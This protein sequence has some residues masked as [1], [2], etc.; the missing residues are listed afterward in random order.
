M[1]VEEFEARFKRQMDKIR[2]YAR[3]KAPEA[4]GVE[5]VN[6]FKEAFDKEAFDGKKWE[7]VERRNS[8]SLWYGH[9]GQTGRFSEAR[10]T[11]RILTGETGDLRNAIRPAIRPGGVTIKNEKVYAAVHNFGGPANVYGKKPFTMKKRQFMGVTPELEK[12]IKEK[13]ERDIRNILNS[14]T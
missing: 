1:T 4:I 13:L 8:D 7:D 2:T 11:A 3:D 14:Q 6:L 10:T 9:S 12:N 5:A